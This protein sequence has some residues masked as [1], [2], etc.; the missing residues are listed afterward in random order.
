[1]VKTRQNFNKDLQYYKFCLYGFFKNLRFFEPFLILFF[2][3]K[4]LS[5]LQIGTLY[6]IREI[7]KNIFEI[8]TGIIADSIGRRRTMITAFIIYIISFIT[9]YF[10]IKYLFFI[11][12]MILYS[13][14]DA[15]RT[16][17]HK[18][19]IFEYLKIKGWDDQ[20]VYYYGNTRSFS[21]LGSAISSLIAGF[22]IFFTGSYKFI[23][24]YS[25]IPYILDLILIM[26]YPKVLDGNVQK[27]K[28]K[29]IKQNFKK[30]IKDFIFSFKDIKVLKAI[31]NLS[32]YTGFYRA[33]KDYLQP[34][35]MT[36]ALALPILVFFED[37]QRASIIIGIVYFIIYILT[38]FAAR[39]SGKTAARFKNLNIPLN[40]TLVIGLVLGILSGIF[41]N[42]HLTLISIILYIGLYLVENLRK[43]MGV[44]YITDMLKRDILT[45][46]L[47][48]ESQTHTLIA[49]I[50]APLLG[51]FADKYGVGNAMII[52]SGI[53]ILTVP[54]FLVYEKKK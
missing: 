39:K 54:F 28:G 18:A 29:K 34:V 45:T 21:Q 44:A 1:M 40:L 52:I 5:F 4:E 7:T 2:L 51:F 41:Y 47:S 22:I 26:T 17:T 25:T 49:A 9:F 50:I 53:L 33:V 13:F 23:F 35:L 42:L 19:M 27:I 24:L 10:S 30:V 38:S 15:F 14:G 20:K 6:A 3:D 32:V 43:P 36:F 37:K 12:A 48:A 16:G 11:I 8:P 46:A 31:A